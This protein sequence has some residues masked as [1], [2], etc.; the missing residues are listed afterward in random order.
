MAMLLKSILN[1]TSIRMFVAVVI[2]SAVFLVTPGNAGNINKKNQP[3]NSPAKEKVENKKSENIEE[4][5]AAASGDEG[6]GSRLTDEHI[7]LQ[8]DGF[9][10]RPRPLLEIGQNFLGTGTLP[11]GLKLPTGAV[12]QPYFMAFGTIRSGLQSFNNGNDQFSEWA[13]RLDL[14][15]N[16]YL[17]FTERILV[18]FRPLDREG[19]FTGAVL[20]AP[21]N[22]EGIKT[23][24]FQDEFNFELTTLF[25]EGDFGELFPNLD[26]DDDGGLDYGLSIGRQ[27]IR[28]QEGM[29]IDD[30]IDAIGITKINWKFPSSAVNFRWTALFGW[31]ELNRM[32][33]ANDDGGSWL[34]G[35]LTETDFRS[36]TV[37]I[38][39]IYVGASDS[40]IGDGIYAGISA[41]QRIGTLNTSFRAL[42]SFPIGDEVFH[43]QFGVL[44]FSEVSW[45][46]HGNHNF[47]YINNFLGLKNYRSASRAPSAGGPLGRTGILFAGA[48]LG[49][50]GGGSALGNFAD[51]AV[52]GALGYQ[53][54]FDHTRKQILF[55]V[56]GRYDDANTFH[57]NAVAGGA[58]YQMALGRR[59]VFQ[60]DGALI[61]EFEPSDEIRFGGRLELLIQM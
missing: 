22:I 23:G 17:T 47:W 13:N 24:E 51:K 1:F 10:K 36:S 26:K 8:L 50:F 33:L 53:L 55:E 7:P 61:K 46:P 40:S 44:L 16:L 30:N 12:W 37:A 4:A 28:F 20:Q 43:N 2:C 41:V 49:Q 42:G 45:T 35:L 27:P 9:P 15:G 57:Q 38:D 31:N 19:R 14:F 39:A 59:F 21:D 54:F 11:Q 29:L 3:E 58:R 60:L 32:N 6:H 34:G 18:G 25:F 56:G 5:N 48:G 52:G